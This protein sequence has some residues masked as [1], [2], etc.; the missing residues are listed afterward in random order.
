[1]TRSHLIMTLDNGLVDLVVGHYVVGFSVAVGFL[2]WFDG[3]KKNAPKQRPLPPSTPWKFGNVMKTTIIDLLYNRGRETHLL[4]WSLTGVHIIMDV[5]SER[6]RNDLQKTRWKW[7]VTR[8]TGA[9]FLTA[10]TTAI[11]RRTILGI[12]IET[13]VWTR[14]I[15]KEGN[16]HVEHVVIFALKT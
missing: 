7:T 2:L 13:R 10:D 1:M 6:V 5:V 8:N 3:D 14:R 9:N 12:L 15:R 4:L 16:P 11:A